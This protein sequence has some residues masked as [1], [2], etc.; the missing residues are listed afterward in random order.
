MTLTNNFTHCFRVKE[1][2]LTPPEPPPPHPH[3]NQDCS[4]EAT[5]W[6]S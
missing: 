3:Q 6:L 2:N 5:V 1:C 4:S